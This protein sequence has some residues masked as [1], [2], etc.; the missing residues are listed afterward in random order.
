VY[1][2]RFDLGQVPVYFDDLTLSGGG[3]TPARAVSWGEM[4]ARYR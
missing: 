3:A 1:N 4:K 2:F